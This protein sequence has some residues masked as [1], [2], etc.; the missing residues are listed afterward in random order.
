MKKGIL[1]SVVLVC[2]LAVIMAALASCGSE[3]EEATYESDLDKLKSS[4]SKMT[5]S[6]TYESMESFEAAWDD[7]KSAY[8]DLVVSANVAGKKIDNLKDAFQGLVD[9]IG[10]ITSEQSLEQKVNGIKS[11]LE[12]LDDAVKAIKPTG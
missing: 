9:A 1:I 10:N 8:D 7:V 6:K 3:D 11:A 12:D 5:E 4:I 2:V